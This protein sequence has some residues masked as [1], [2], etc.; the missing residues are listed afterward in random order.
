MN[1]F[2]TAIS[3][4]SSA[5]GRYFSV[6][7]FIPS[8]FLTGFTFLLIESGAWGEGAGLDWA[9]AGNA[10]TH[11]GDLALLTLISMVLGIAA[12]PIQF[13]LIQFFEGYWGTGQLAQ[14]VRVARM[15]HH[16]G[17]FIFLRHGPGP[18]AR[19]ELREAAES[20]E[21]FKGKARIE[22]LSI[23]EES[24]RLAGEYP[25]EDDDIMPTRLGNVLRRYERLAGSQY[26]LDAGTVIRHIAFVAPPERLGY[27]NDQ[28]QL[29]DLSVRMCA[30]SVLATLIAIASFWPHG[31]WLLLALVPYAIAYVS[32]RGAVVVAREYG[33]AFATI[34][35]LDRFA[36]Y[37]YLRVPLPK[38]TDAER[39]ANAQLMRLLS[40]NRRVVLP[41]EHP[42]A[43]ES[44]DK[45]LKAT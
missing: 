34:I 32:Y 45:E 20:G 39:H 44:T 3:G 19:I 26:G 43:A 18:E 31:P 22:R 14:R 4:V 28:R 9:K 38:N 11:I 6:V 17:R 1:G 10:F 30:T 2:S 24:R 8:L 41:Y 27:L 5:M 7:S 33:A 23:S 36:F 16:R 21:P 15:L 37:D 25:A 13:A 42:P 35:D 29:L 40:H 12:H